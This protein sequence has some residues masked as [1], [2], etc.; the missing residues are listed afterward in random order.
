MA[1]SSFGSFIGHRGVGFQPTASR[2]GSLP[3]ARV[4][5]DANVPHLE[6]PGRLYGSSERG[7]GSRNRERERDRTRMTRP[8]GPQEGADW[9]VLIT[10]IHNRLEALERLNRGIS[11]KA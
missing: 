4:R 11:D 1:S 7:S 6:G 5:D 3:P 10:N 9:D 2:T 8:M